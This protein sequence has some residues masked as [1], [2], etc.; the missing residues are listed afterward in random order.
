MQKRPDVAREPSEKG[1]KETRKKLDHMHET[2]KLWATRQRNIHGKDG[3]RLGDDTVKTGEQTNGKQWLNGI[4]DADS[5]EKNIT[6]KKESKPQNECRRVPTIMIRKGIKK[7]RRCR[8]NGTDF[9]EPGHGRQIQ[10]KM[11]LKH[12]RRS[13]AVKSCRHIVH[14]RTFRRARLSRDNGHQKRSKKPMMSDV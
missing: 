12:L 3:R 8:N 11:P 9:A 5:I 13:A 10:T 6:T 7:T 14:N 1:D 4:K 2:T